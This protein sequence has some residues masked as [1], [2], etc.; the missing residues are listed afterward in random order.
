MAAVERQLA[1]VKEMFNT[2]DRRIKT[3]LFLPVYYGNYVELQ[4]TEYARTYPLLWNA[5]K[6][7]Q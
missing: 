6:Q 2:R 5:Q 1:N 3:P 7:N 4:K